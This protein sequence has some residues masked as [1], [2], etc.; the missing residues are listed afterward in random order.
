[1]PKVRTPFIGISNVSRWCREAMT[2]DVG[3]TIVPAD[4]VRTAAKRN[5]AQVIVEPGT[6][7]NHRKPKDGMSLARVTVTGRKPDVE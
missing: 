7:V 5:G 2:G 1:M 6:W 3:F 4:T